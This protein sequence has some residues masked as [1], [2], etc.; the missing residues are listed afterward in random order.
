MVGTESATERRPSIPGVPGAAFVGR[1]V[2]LRT[3]GLALAR[4]RD[5]AASSIVVVSGP[6]GI[7]KTRLLAEVT[8]R[9]GARIRAIVGRG[10]PLGSAVPFSLVVE[11]LEAHLRPLGDVTVRA[12]LG[13][14]GGALARVLPSA[15]AVFGDEAPLTPLGTLEAFLRVFAQLATER[16]L[17]VVL[18]DVH[19]ADP[20]TLDLIG[21]L[22]RNP[23]GARVLVIAAVREQALLANT[24]ASAV[25]GPLLKDGLAS[26][27][28]LGPLAQEDVRALARAASADPTAEGIA[29]RVYELARGNPLFSVALLGEPLVGS[30][31]PRTVQDHV[32]ARMTPLESD[33]RAVL[34]IAAALGDS[35]SLATI[36]A[37]IGEGGAPRLDDLVRDG[38]LVVT[39]AP[40]PRYDF[41]HPV[42]REAIYDGIG[43]AARRELH[44]RI[45][46]LGTD[47]A[48]AH[49]AYHALR[50]ALPGDNEMLDLIRAGARSAEDAQRHREAVTLL[51]GALPLQGDGPERIALLDELAGQASEIGDHTTGVPALRE[52]AK[53]RAGD[54]LGEADARM[55]LASLLASG[56]GDLEAAAVAARAALELFTRG[57]AAER[58]ASARNELAWIEGQAGDVAAQIS[59]SAAAL[60]RAEARGETVSAVHALGSLSHALALEGRW[61]EAMHASQRGVALARETGERAQLQWHT[62]NLGET[63]AAAGRY[64]E[65]T[66]LFDGLLAG[67]AIESDLPYSRRAFV[68]WWAGRWP[69]AQADCRAAAALYPEAIPVHSAWVLSL[70]ALLAA[71]T[72]QVDQ[73]RRALLQADRVYLASAHYWFSG[74]HAWATA[75]ACE[76][77]GDGAEAQRRADRAVHEL[78]RLGAP[79]PLLQVLP[80]VVALRVNAG[81]TAGASAAAER[82]SALAARLGTPLARALAAFGAGLA[83]RGPAGERELEVALSAS[84]ELGIPFIAARAAEELARRRPEAGRVELLREAARL[85]AALPAPAFAERALDALRGLGTAGRRAAQLVGALTPREREV[86]LLAKRG[87]R[88]REIAERLGLSERTVE[89]HLAHVYGKLRV[90]DREGLASVDL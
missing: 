90:S 82:L 83:G 55:R 79:V 11:G 76:I 69:M 6:P 50:A 36:A 42:V 32:R 75:L 85:Y 27:L 73:A 54:P 81:D 7:G 89:S 70:S 56:S 62:A 22:G 21:Y 33:A 43:A 53:L 41:A 34:E 37:L 60:E 52:L 47:A 1:A 45:A 66:A 40:A 35:F 77:L 23:L 10:S 28:R 63:L 80:D 78:E 44:R 26:E 64:P 74:R 9:S 61:D 20:S 87:L 88:T 16:P 57:G 30:S 72:G 5:A 84:Q 3:L 8:A 68:N 17:V 67:E 15:A 24:A 48:P 29:D 13:A 46:R 59:G 31:A 49:R 58:V 25:L 19:E 4:A 18:D 86:A 38:F 51:A 2:E 12:I 71:A 65:S 39:D 14:Q